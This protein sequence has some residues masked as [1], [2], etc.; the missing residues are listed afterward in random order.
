MS[1]KNTTNNTLTEWQMQLLASIFRLTV[2]EI[3]CDEDKE[4]LAPGEIGINYVNGTFYVRNP[5]NGKLFTPNSL[6]H[7][8][9]ILSKFDP[10]NN[11]LNADI[12]SG[13]RV[14]NNLN[15]LEYLGVDFTPDSVIRQMISPSIFIGP[16]EY[17]NN[18]ALGWPSNYG[19]LLVYKGDDE[20]TIIKYFDTN[21]YVSYDG[22]YNRHI[23]LFE[24]WGLSG[25]NISNTFVET[26]GGGDSTSA[27]FEGLLDDL[28]VIT[29]RIS[30]TLNPGATIDINNIGP[31]QIVDVN[32]EPISYHIEANNII[33]LIYDKN[34]SRWILLKSTDTAILTLIQILNG[35]IN[36]LDTTI[37][38]EFSKQIDSLYEHIE[39]LNKSI[40]ED[41]TES[42]NQ[43]GNTLRDEMRKTFTDFNEKLTN[44]DNKFSTRPGNI[45][46][47]I[48]N[49]TAISDNITEI[50]VIDGFVGTYDKLIVNYGQTILR[51]G[52]DYNITEDNG[53]ILKNNITLAKDDV[54]QFIILKQA[55][56]T[57]N[58]E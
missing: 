34:E 52:I 13:I 12:I 49:Y 23:H 15:Q 24:G 56:P 17:T 28:S 58:E 44:L 21:S 25:N 50:A 54:V 6:E 5:H 7:I 4:K 47:L 40:R 31:L 1:V 11:I 53:I 16:I 42:I 27:F 37:H 48:V 55:K 46:A 19:M 26:V 41:F 38:D 3:V 51:Q 8:K 30:E 39:E 35:R 57:L 14:Y 33:M 9:L 36:T 22:K 10:T 2:K 32:G 18:I 20:H 29:V 43:L 45:D